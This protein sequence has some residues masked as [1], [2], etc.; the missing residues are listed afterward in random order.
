MS[1][2]VNE[3]LLAISQMTP[4]TYV[5]G[6]RQ[7]VCTEEEVFFLLFYSFLLFLMGG[8]DEQSENKMKHLHT[9]IYRHTYTIYTEQY[10]A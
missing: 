8:Q 6:N 4:P 5:T 9:D 10:I 3:L 2:S 7:H 1:N